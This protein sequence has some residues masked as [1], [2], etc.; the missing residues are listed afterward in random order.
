MIVVCFI[1]YCSYRFE[2]YMSLQDS[3]NLHFFSQASHMTFETLTLASFF[4]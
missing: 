1:N 2:F 3:Q 4:I